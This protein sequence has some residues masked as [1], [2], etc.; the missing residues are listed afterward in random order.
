[1]SEISNKDA[2]EQCQSRVGCSHKTL[3]W[4]EQGDGPYRCECVTCDKVFVFRPAMR[5]R[6][7]KEPACKHINTRV[8]PNTQPGKAECQ[9]CGTVL[10][11]SEAY[12]ILLKEMQESVRM[13]D[14]WKGIALG[15]QKQ[16]GYAF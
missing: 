10:P 8:N 3:K 4:L 7:A 12:S 2:A 16:C 9:D 5:D 14:A 13:A 1:M 15:Y 6:K 11:L